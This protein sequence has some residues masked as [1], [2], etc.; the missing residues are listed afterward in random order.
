MIEHSRFKHLSMFA[1]WPINHQAFPG[2]D[3]WAQGPY[4]DLLIT[5]YTVC[6]QEMED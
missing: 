2:L 3:G 5:D 4:N 1:Q 6:E